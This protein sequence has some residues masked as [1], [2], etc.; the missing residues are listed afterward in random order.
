MKRTTTSI[1]H[2]GID[3]SKKDFHVALVTDETSKS[4]PQKTFPNTSAGFKSLVKWLEDKKDSTLPL[5]A[6]LEATGSYGDALSYFLNSKVYK[7]S[8]VNPRAIKA[9]GDS[10]LRRCKS[11][12]ADARLIANYCM[13]KKPAAWNEPTPEQRHVKELS[14]RI[15]HLKT[16]LRKELNRL[17]VTHDKLVAKDLKEHVRWM[18]KHIEKLDANL[19][20]SIKADELLAESFE[21]LVSI[22]GIGPNTAAYLLAEIPDASLF[23]NA[24]QLAAYAG[25]TPRIFQSGTSGRTRTPMSKAGNRHIRKMLF[26]PA[27]SAM[28]YNPVCK[29]FAERLLAKGKSKMEVI[30]A[31]MNKLLRIIYGVLKSR[32]PFDANIRTALISEV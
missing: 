1:K 22:K 32:S 13:I 21:L 17:E 4:I 24:R 25:T 30:G 15:S 2:L 14:R 16:M 26:F 28:R 11:D 31:V 9:Y 3:I 6:C 5:H 7:L 23:Q 18:E 10:D 20:A 27:M 19:V 8:V 12:S 29:E